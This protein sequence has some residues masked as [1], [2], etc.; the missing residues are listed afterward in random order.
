MA[1]ASKGSEGIVIRLIGA[2]STIRS[3][4]RTVRR[5]YPDDIDDNG[6]SAL[7]YAAQ[8]SHENIT[9][10]LLNHR[11]DISHSSDHF[12]TVL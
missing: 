7:H 12:G 8:A 6:F 10:I 4:N 9:K 1:A 3:V 2:H 5:A 11:V